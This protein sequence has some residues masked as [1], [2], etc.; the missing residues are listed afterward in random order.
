MVLALQFP[1]N[2]NQQDVLFISIYFNN[3]YTEL[4]LLMKTSSKTARN[5]YRL[6]IQINLK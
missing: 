2:K 5:M 1:N 4:I 6:I 3:Q